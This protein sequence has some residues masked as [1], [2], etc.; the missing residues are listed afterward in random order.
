[1]LLVLTHAAVLVSFCTQI[2][3]AQSKETRFDAVRTIISEFNR[4][5]FVGLG[6][7]H[8]GVA[9]SEFRKKLIR[10]REFC[11]KVNDIVVEFANPLYQSVL[12]RF[13]NGED[14]SLVSGYFFSRPNNINRMRL[15]QGLCAFPMTR[16]F[17]QTASIGRVDGGMI[18]R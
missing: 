10:D 6:E 4:A 13:V 3:S 9:D 8:S 2:G 14:L 5:T 18:P 16:F 17:G 11:R 7:L 15:L 1:M 12:D